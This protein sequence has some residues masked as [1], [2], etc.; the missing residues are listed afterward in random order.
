MIITK[1]KLFF[2]PTLLSL[3]SYQ[4]DKIL[5]C[6]CCY[7]HGYL[8]NADSAGADTDS[9]GATDSADLAD[10]TD[11]ADSADSADLTDSGDSTDSV[12]SADSTDSANSDFNPHLDIFKTQIFII[13]VIGSLFSFNRV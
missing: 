2:L 10:S 3:H 7:V 8:Q 5:F 11:S 6:Y 13:V 9:A 4:E 1:N 12:D